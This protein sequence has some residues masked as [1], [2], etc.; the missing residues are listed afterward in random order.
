[1][2]DRPGCHGSRAGIAWRSIA[3][4]GRGGRRHLARRLTG[5]QRPPSVRQPT[6]SRRMATLPLVRPANIFRSPLFAATAL[7]L[8]D[9]Q[10]HSMS[11]ACHGSHRCQTAP[12]PP[13]RGIGTSGISAAVRKVPRLLRSS[14]ST[15]GSSTSTHESGVAL[16]QRIG[17]PIALTCPLSRAEHRRDPCR[18]MAETITD[19]RVDGSVTENPI[20]SLTQEPMS[21]ASSFAP[22]RILGWWVVQMGK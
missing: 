9:Q 11:W 1:M 19:S 15:Q 16:E 18:S 17:Y 2:D 3:S 4:A 5:P 21:G 8:L 12:Q 13:A 7:A 22:A 14:T 10:P 20:D 6:G